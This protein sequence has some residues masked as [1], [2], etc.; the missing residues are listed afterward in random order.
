[1]TLRIDH[2]VDGAGVTADYLNGLLQL[3]GQSPC[4]AEVQIEEACTYGDQMVS[5][6]ARVL[7]S[8]RYL[9][10]QGGGWPTR[11]VLKI[12]RTD[13]DV[14]APFYENEVAF[15]TRL[16]PE[17][18]IEAPLSLGGHYDPGTRHFAVLMEN[19]VARG[20]H[21]PNVLDTVPTERVR[22]LLET[23]ARLHARYWNAAELSTTL[24]W[25]GTALEGK[26]ATLLNDAAA[27]Y[28]QYEIDN[29]KFKNELVGMLGWT[30]EELRTG[31]M[32]MHRHQLRLDQ[33]VVH[34]DTHLGNT[35]FLPEGRC[36]L[37]DWQLMGRGHPMH[38]V[39]YIIAT[40]LSVADRRVHEQSLLR[41]Y[42]DR[43]KAAGAANPPSFEDSWDE[44]RRSMIWNVY[45]G[46]LTTPVVN[47]GWEINVMNHIRLVTAFEDLE[48]GKLVRAV[49]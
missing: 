28:I 7:F 42:L 22:S 32:A 33:C 10:G 2:P 8:V 30:G 45:V 13:D 6:A 48:T 17:L 25:M 14:M 1:V 41:Y 11:Q 49:M 18:D 5:T 44:Y 20:A 21:F 29:Q 46:W 43:L 4:I 24:G 40:A 34:G 3:C 16:R 38:D 26:V 31:T 27:P 23:L 9:D 12:A 39:S 19:L 47:Y 35:Y 15:Y 37:L 36:G